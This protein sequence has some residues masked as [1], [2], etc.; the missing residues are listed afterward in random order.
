M[1]HLGKC[2]CWATT[3]KVEIQKALLAYC[4]FHSP[5]SS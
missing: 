5:L 4:T 3:Q 2:K 1:R